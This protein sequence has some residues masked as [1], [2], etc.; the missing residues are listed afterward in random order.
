[1]SA[2][3][4]TLNSGTSS[5]EVD[6]LDWQHQYVFTPITESL[7]PEGIR[8]HL[9]YLGR[10]AAVADVA[11]GTG[12]WLRDAAKILP[13]ETSFDGY[14]FD[15]SKFPNPEQLP[16]NIKL[17]WGDGLKPFPAEVQGHY[18]LVHV[19]CLMYGLKADQ[20]KIMVENLLS[21]LRPGGYL[22]WDEVGYPSF[23]CLPMTEAFQKFIS[24]DVRYAASVG[25]DIT[26]PV[27]LGNYMKG[28]G[29][30]DC[31][32]VTFSSF[33]RPKE[34]QHLAGE[35]IIQG[36]GQSI[37]GIVTRGGFEWAQK[38]E[39]VQEVTKQLR[40]D[41]DDGKCVLGFEVYWAIGRKA[42]SR[43]NSSV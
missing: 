35:V 28:V 33:S 19:R 40:T 10:P 8:Q 16:S 6:R 27:N 41:V 42:Y 4:Y 38:Q 29:L 21:L 3:V 30:V 12:I 5:V 26:S 7:M 11:T 1:M 17:Q 2:S 43:P 13:P 39:D 18:D 37:S 14:D 32:Q 9:V 15:T 23:M 20:W 31:R 24:L 34:I 36:V 25:R 22:L